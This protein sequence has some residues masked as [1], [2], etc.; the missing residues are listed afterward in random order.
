MAAY[1]CTDASVKV[2][3]WRSLAVRLDPVSSSPQRICELWLTKIFMS[4]GIFNGKEAT[5]VDFALDKSANV[6]L[7]G[8]NTVGEYFQTMVLWCPNAPLA[9][10]IW[11]ID[12]PPKFLLVKVANHKFALVGSLAPG[13]MPLFP[14]SFSIDV[15]VPEALASAT[16]KGNSMCRRQ[17]SC[18]TPFV[19]TDYR[20][21][22]RTFSNVILDLEPPNSRGTR[23]GHHT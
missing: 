9:G 2:D 21:Q 12:S 11:I 14:T 16:G 4:L 7:F 19:I 1:D 20:S 15:H 13:Q 10:T 23:G 6:Y 8:E 22:G 18:C 17:I 3:D 5:T